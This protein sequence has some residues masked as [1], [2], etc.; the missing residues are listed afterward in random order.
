VKRP[1]GRPKHRWEDNI[2]IDLGE[3]VS[4]GVDW[5]HLS[6]GK[7]KWQASLNMVINLW[8]P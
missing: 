7:D 2:R 4:E 1:L 3:T 8:V 6:Q 5:M